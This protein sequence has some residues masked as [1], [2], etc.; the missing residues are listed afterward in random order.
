MSL[1]RNFVSG[2]RALFRREQVD[3]ELDEELRA[4]AEMAID[5]KMKQG[6]SRPD[7][8]R[9]VRLER[10]SLEATKEVVRSAGWESLLETSWQDLRFGLRTLRK[11][12][13]FTCVAVLTLA[14][15]IGA[16]TAV[17]SI[18][19]AVLLRPLPYKNAERL[20][21]V[22]CSEI[23]AQLAAQSASSL[24]GSAENGIN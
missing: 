5:E 21:A 13:G 8:L 6:L 24:C 17:F 1:L 9:A 22:W 3:R 4:Y 18:V 10:G 20:V 2:L 7:A 16:N 11:I 14:V 15:A 12:P 23:A 19:D